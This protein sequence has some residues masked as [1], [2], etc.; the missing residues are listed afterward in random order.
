MS[1]DIGAIIGTIGAILFMIEL[2]NSFHSWVGLIDYNWA[3]MI[4]PI[5]LILIGLGFMLPHENNEI[6]KV[7]K[8][9]KK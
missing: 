1:K 6:I 9:E 7:N 3:I 2:M 8:E 4:F 5:C